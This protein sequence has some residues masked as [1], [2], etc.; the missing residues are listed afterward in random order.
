MRGSQVHLDGKK[1]PAAGLLP[2]ERSYMVR[3]IRARSNFWKKEPGMG[4]EPMTFR[5]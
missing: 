4:F 1:K 5:L 3:A 2:G